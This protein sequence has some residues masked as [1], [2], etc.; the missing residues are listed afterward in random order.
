MG[1]TPDLDD[2]LR[3]SAF[4]YLDRL[5]TSSGGLVTITPDYQ[6]KAS[7]RLRTEFQNG[8]EYFAMEGEELW[9]PER[10][11]DRPSPE[12]L[13]WHRQVAFLG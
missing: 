11:E 5:V 12:F 13:E 9:L 3:A 10:P 2:R 7:R 8:E 4:G 1:N 6:F